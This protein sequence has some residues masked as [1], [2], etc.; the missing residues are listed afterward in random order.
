MKYPLNATIKIQHNSPCFEQLFC[1]SLIT[2]IK[3]ECK[4]YAVFYS[5]KTE[6]YTELQ[7]IVIKGT[8]DDELLKKIKPFKAR[9]IE[10]NGCVRIEED[11]LSKEN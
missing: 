10:E 11:I 3:R 5:L 9:I 7:V 8:R 6:H 4:G 2:S 1:K